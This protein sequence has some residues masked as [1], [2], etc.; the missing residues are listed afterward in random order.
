MGSTLH[1]YLFLQVLGPFVGGLA[2]FT[3]VLLIARILK[4]VEMVVNRGVPALQILQLFSYILP[5]FLEVTVPMALLLACLMAFGRLSA[6]SEIVALR[7]AGLSL[8]QISTS[9][10]A[11]ALL[12]W[13]VSLGLSLYARPWG[14]EALRNGIFELARTRASVGLKQH[15][16]NDEF[17]GLVIY[18]EQIEPPGNELERIVISDRRQAGEENTVIARRGQL[19][20]DERAHSVNLRLYD[21]F[22]FTNPDGGGEY[23]KTDFNV[24]DVSLDL[25]HALGAVEQRERDPSEMRTKELRG[26]IAELRSGGEPALAE[27]VELE[28]RLSVPFASLVFALVGVPL[29]LQP[30]RAVRS[31]GLALSLGI[32]LLYYLMLSGGETLGRQGRAPITLA[33]W[34]P[35]LVLGA[36]GLYLF[37]RAA[38]ERPPVGR[39]WLDALSAAAR[40]RWVAWRGAF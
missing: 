14:N 30:V 4:L 1:R 8:Y 27:R 26:R 13:I 18:V 23:D 31:R 22:I 20:A 35:N 32:I 17:P 28:R 15:V 36:V 19:L 21:G 2:L 11:F 40:S 9:V 5:A 7:A 12:I 16:F 39:G 29:G 33:L 6:D 24:Y 34:M 38:R 10:A 3:F 25:G 37:L